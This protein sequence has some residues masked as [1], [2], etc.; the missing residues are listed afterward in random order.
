LA[1]P[2]RPKSASDAPRHFSLKR[3]SD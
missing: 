3:R 1:D 2:K